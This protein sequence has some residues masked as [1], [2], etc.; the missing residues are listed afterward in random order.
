[1][2]GLFSPKAHAPDT[3]LLK[4]DLSGFVDML[5]GNEG[6]ELAGLLILA[7]NARLQLANKD[8]VYE[9]AFSRTGLGSDLSLAITKADK[10]VRSFQR[11]GQ[12]SDA[13]GASIWLHTLR[14]CQHEE[15]EAECHAMWQELSRGMP[16]V[17]GV[18]TDLKARAPELDDAIQ[19]AARFVPEGWGS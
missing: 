15:L 17:D 14:A 3:D 11:A 8:E 9:R 5:K 2:F 4:K 1:M 16:D 6:V 19:E 13:A 7:A 12:L 18:F 10:L